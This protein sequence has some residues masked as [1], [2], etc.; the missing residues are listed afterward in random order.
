VNGKIHS[1]EQ[2]KD[3]TLYL[4]GPPFPPVSG[5]AGKPQSHQGQGQIRMIF[6]PV[7]SLERD[8]G[9]SSLIFDVPL[10]LTAIFS[11]KHWSN[12]VIII[13]MVLSPTWLSVC[14]Q[15]LRG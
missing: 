1:P 12:I 2:S 14:G 5:N 8:S 13:L 4:T 9:F 10:L 7:G 11:Q 3:D 15:R 6:R